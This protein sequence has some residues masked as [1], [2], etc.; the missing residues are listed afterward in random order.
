MK[1]ILIRMDPNAAI[2]VSCTTGTSITYMT[3]ICITRTAT[4]SMSM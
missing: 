1:I 4:I 2:Q 3:G